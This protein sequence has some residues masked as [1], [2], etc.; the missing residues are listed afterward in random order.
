M[1]AVMDLLLKESAASGGVSAE[2]IADAL[3][4]SIPSLPTPAAPS[5]GQWEGRQVL[6][7]PD[8]LLF[9]FRKVGRL[10]QCR[11]DR[12]WLHLRNQQLLQ[13][14]HCLR[15][16]FHRVGRWNG[17]NIMAISGYYKANG[18]KRTLR[19][20]Y[21]EHCIVR[22]PKLEKVLKRRE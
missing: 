9:K 10:L 19:Q 5:R 2:E 11:T 16:V 3:A 15:V 12:P 1:Q 4:K 7:Q 20:T 6:F 14:L 13:H 18:E 8:A 22:P 21:G 17:G